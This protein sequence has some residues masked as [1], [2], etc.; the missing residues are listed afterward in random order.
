MD[1]I[2][3]FLQG[4]LLQRSVSASIQKR[5]TFES[6]ITSARHSSM[7]GLITSLAV[8]SPAVCC[9]KKNASTSSSSKRKQSILHCRSQGVVGGSN[10]PPPPS[11]KNFWLRNCTI[12]PYI[13]FFQCANANNVRLVN[14]IS[15]T[16][17][18]SQIV[19]FH[20]ISGAYSQAS[21]CMRTV[22]NNATW[23][24]GRR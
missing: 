9:F 16:I 10:T 1:V 3:Y 24:T 23:N 11:R 21:T 14:L 20:Y 4:S 7:Q 13:P 8:S 19:A 15:S 6:A 5:G 17:I 2:R 18:F 22:W 12:A